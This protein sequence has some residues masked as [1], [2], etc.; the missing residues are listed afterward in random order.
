MKLLISAALFLQTFS[1]FA[2]KKEQGFDYFFKPTDYAPRYYVLTEKKDS[3]WHRQAWYLPER[4]MAMEGWYK[5]EECKTPHGTVSW[6]H[7][8]K[9]LK[10]RG[11]YVSGEREGVW[12]QFDE[13]GRLKDSA[14]YVAG[15]L[16]GVRMQWHPNGMPADSMEFDGAGNGVEVRWYND[17]GLSAA[18]YWVSDTVKKGRWQ[19]FDSKG[20]IL[21]T[22]DYK[23]G[24][25]IA[26]ACFDEAGIKL[27]PADCIEKEAEI[28]GGIE[29][30]RRFLERNL[31]LEGPVR[32]GAPSGQYTV[33]VR[34]LVDKDGTV[35]DVKPM[36]HYGYGME[37][38]VVDLMKRAP[39]WKPGQQH[40]R[41]VK[42]YHTQ[43]IT[44]DISR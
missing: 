29:V 20:K 31:N 35:T 28:L 40:G 1:L 22:E 19:Y 15:K 7:T 26:S 43:P 32:N 13:E 18:G 12:L 8:T 42:S 2:Q 38:L 16:K 4:S 14:N 39:R 3:L 33:I 36:T 30:W 34:F 44:M 10:S 41:K 11:A 24:K 23:E 27:D 6:Y 37:E 17:G 9:F 5:D 25:M 21:A